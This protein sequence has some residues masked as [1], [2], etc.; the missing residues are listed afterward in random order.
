MRRCE[1]ACLIAAAALVGVAACRQ[2]STSPPA[3]ISDSQVTAAVAA[4]AGAT[5]AGDV[6]ALV[7]DEIAIALPNA[8][9]GL[10]L[11]GSRADS[12]TLVR[13]RT[14][15]DATDAVVADCAL[16]TTRRI[17]FHVRMDG[18]RT[19]AAVTGR[20]HRDR[21]WTLTRNFNAAA[22]PVE[23]SRTHD[24]AGASHD[25]LTYVNAST[26]V[27]RVHEEAAV[28]S[29]VGVTWT[30]PRLTHPWP[31]AGSV[32]RNVTVH[33]TADGPTSHE[34]RDATRR[35]AVDFP[36]DAQGNVVLHINALTCDLNLLTHAVTG[37]H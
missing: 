33:V 30:L 5:I 12:V 21:D 25:T 29:V 24:G 1:F 16:S 4:S 28:D 18:V 9:V 10:D 17:V 6:A 19:G 27:T 34:T 23:V 32:V 7:G 13:T 2:D 31:V 22:P 14:C 36:P 8:A 3:L 35:V 37:C 20:V 15:Y 11:F 26:G